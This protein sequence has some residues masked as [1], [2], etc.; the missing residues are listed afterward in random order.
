MVDNPSDPDAPSQSA[1]RKVRPPVIELEAT[2]VTPEAPGRTEAPEASAEPARETKGCSQDSMQNPSSNSG[3]HGSFRLIALAGFTGAI[4]GALSVAL[5][6]IFVGDGISRFM[7]PSGV[8]GLSS[9]SGVPS[10]AGISGD[11]AEQLAKVANELER[12]IAAMEN[13]G[14][15][16]ASDMAPLIS[17]TENIETALS[18]LRRLIEQTQAAHS[19]SAEVV[20]GR[21]AAIENRLTQ[22]ARTAIANAAEI[23]ALGTLQDAIAK[24]IPFAKELAAAR[25][26]LGDRAASLAPVGKFAETGVPTIAA[27]SARFAEL[28]PKLVREPDSDSGYIA[29]LLAHAGRLVEVRPVGEVQGMN[30]GA[31]VAR[32][33]TRLARNDL[34]AAIEETSKLPAAAKMEAAD[35]IAAATNHRDA[36]AAVKNLLSA[37]LINSTAEQQK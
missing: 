22:P 17:R 18:D 3:T 19:A 8:G 2:D 21:I 5:A 25:T 24:G 36:E 1:R 31:V 37:A 28:V 27:L 10:S 9:A 29:R 32:I 11:R 20:A 12:R 6:L 13:R 26:I 7:P 15:P 4:V 33:E 35:W 30:A 14:T 23:A 34:N 16:Q